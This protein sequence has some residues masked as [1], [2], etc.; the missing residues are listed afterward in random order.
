MRQLVVN[1]DDF[2]FTRDVNRGIVEAHRLGIL[3]AITATTALALWVDILR[4][5]ASLHPTNPTP[6]LPT[7]TLKP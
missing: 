3:T 5:R 6:L 7:A 4:P 2:G 1:A